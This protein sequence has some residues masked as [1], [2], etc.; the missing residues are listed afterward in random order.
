MLGFKMS[1]TKLS[2]EKFKNDLP[3]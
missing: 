3:L 1:N 2:K